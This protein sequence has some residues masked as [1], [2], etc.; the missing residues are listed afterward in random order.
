MLFPILLFLKTVILKDGTKPNPRIPGAKE[1]EIQ[2]Q[3][4]K[5]FG[6]G[7]ANAPF[8]AHRGNETED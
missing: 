2:A 7:K 6:P 1:L 5:K 4:L 3:S 8:F